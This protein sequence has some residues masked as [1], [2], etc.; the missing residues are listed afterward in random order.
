MY[1]YTLDIGM[2]VSR[3]VYILFC[4]RNVSAYYSTHFQFYTLSRWKG[5][6]IPFSFYRLFLCIIYIIKND[7]VLD[8]V[9]W[10]RRCIVYRWKILVPSFKVLGKVFEEWIILTLPES[11]CHIDHRPCVKNLTEHLKFQTV[12]IVK[13]F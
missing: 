10:K 9:E 1:A 8:K 2:I 6:F 5:K 11:L 7:R 3:K 12:A 13:V 4:S